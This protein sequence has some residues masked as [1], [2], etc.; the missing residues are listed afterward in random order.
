LPDQL[1]HRSR[2]VLDRNVRVDTVL[3]EQV[4]SLDAKSLE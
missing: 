4:N 1:L 3:I 2:D